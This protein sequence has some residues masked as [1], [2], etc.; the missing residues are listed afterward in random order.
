MVLTSTLYL[1]AQLASNGMSAVMVRCYGYM[2]HCSIHTSTTCSIIALVKVWRYC[3][4]NV[5]HNTCYYMMMS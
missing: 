4:I 3:I 1:G 2:I 5:E